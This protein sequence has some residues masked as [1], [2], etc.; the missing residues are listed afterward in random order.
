MALVVLQHFLAAAAFGVLEEAG[1]RP[2]VVLVPLPWL[3]GGKGLL[4]VSS[5]TVHS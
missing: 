4:A 3:V 5:K 2:H 1:E